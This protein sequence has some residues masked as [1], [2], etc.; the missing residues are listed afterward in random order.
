MDHK[1]KSI[2]LDNVTS[3]DVNKA[4]QRSLTKAC[5]RHGLG[6]YIYAGEDLPEA[7]RTDNEKIPSVEKAPA[8]MRSAQKT[9][10]EKA[11]RSEVKVRESGRKLTIKQYQ[12]ASG[13]PNDKIVLFMKAIGATSYDDLTERQSSDLVAMVKSNRK[14][15]TNGT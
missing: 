10:E 11:V 4:I 14:E 5:A 6:L 7:E 15:G 1:N 8:A 9:A 12:A 2:V 13:C 3:Y